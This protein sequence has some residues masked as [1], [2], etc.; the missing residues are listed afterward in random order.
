MPVDQSL[1]KIQKNLV[2]HGATG[3]MYEYEK[4]TG[5]IE[6]LKFLIEVQGN[7]VGFALPVNWRLFQ[8]VLKEQ[9]V[10][11]YDEDDYCYR[12]AWANLRDWVD[13]QMALLETQMIELPQIFLPFVVNGKGQTLY[14]QI[15][16][17][18]FLLGSGK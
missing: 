17:N 10:R 14:E 13:S 11:R 5:R 6:S 1:S 4:G 3:F 8:A 2:D 7:K 16:G 18:N 15:K 9:N 12:V